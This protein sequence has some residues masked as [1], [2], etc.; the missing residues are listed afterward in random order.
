MTKQEA[1]SQMRAGKKLT[2]VHFSSEEWVKSDETGAV[3][4]FEDG[5]V[6]SER[7]FWHWRTALSWEGGWDLFKS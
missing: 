2:H 1:I 6:C 4:T 5:V 7:E 3:Y